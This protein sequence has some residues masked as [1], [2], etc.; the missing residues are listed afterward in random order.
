MEL[1]VIQNLLGCSLS[2]TATISPGPDTNAISYAMSSAGLW[3]SRASRHLHL[4]ERG[5]CASV[6]HPIV[7]VPIEM[8][9]DDRIAISPEWR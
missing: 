9:D 8:G 5:G 7:T 1:Q 2:E 3:C 6:P 4:W